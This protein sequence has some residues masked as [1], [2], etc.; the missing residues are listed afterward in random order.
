[1][2]NNVPSLLEGSWEVISRVVSALK[3]VITGY[4]YSC[5]TY[6]FPLIATHEPPSIR[7]LHAKFT[8][9]N[10]GPL[11][12]LHGRGAF[13]LPRPG[14]HRSPGPQLL[15]RVPGVRG[16]P[17]SCRVRKG[18]VFFAA[19]SI[20]SW[21]LLRQAS[22]RGCECDLRFRIQ[23]SDLFTLQQLWFCNGS[24]TGACWHLVASAPCPR[25]ETQHMRES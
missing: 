7:Q 22:L 12:P 20:G 16:C 17:G 9:S 1:M 5:P 23:N 10:S 6:I 14:I 21:R 8:N 25:A 3:K 4:K 13:P 15:F 19:K 24:F 18:V 11:G 2:T